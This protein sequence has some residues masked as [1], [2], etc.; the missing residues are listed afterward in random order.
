MARPVLDDAHVHPAIRG[1]IDQHHADTVQAVI[2]AVQQHPVVVV[3]MAMN[4]FPRKAR[5]LLDGAGI[6]HEYLEYGS[7]FSEWRRRTALK[8]WSGWPTLPMVFVRGTLI[9]GASD[10]ERLLASGELARLLAADAP[11]ASP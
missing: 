3:G 7:Y 10:L 6:A 5:R 2:R 9:G 4:P 8:M 1:T 11:A